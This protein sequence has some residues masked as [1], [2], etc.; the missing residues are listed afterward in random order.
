VSPVPKKTLC[1]AFRINQR[2][3][4]WLLLAGW[5]IKANSLFNFQNAQVDMAPRS[6]DDDIIANAMTE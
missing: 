5:P 3:Q 2:R 4:D 1:K 6:L